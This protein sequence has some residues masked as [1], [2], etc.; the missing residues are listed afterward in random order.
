MFYGMDVAGFP[1]P[2]SIVAAAVCSSVSVTS[3]SSA[4]PS[5]ATAGLASEFVITMRDA[6]ANVVDCNASAVSVWLVGGGHAAADIQ[7]N[8]GGDC[9]VV[10]AVIKVR[11]MLLDVCCVACD[12]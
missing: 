5:V 2:V 4:F 3:S 11:M 12:V 1:Q 7:R 6:S 10:V 9:K 8:D